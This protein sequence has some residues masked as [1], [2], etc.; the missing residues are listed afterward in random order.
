MAVKFWNV[1]AIVAA[2]LGLAVPEGLDSCAIG[3]P[4][5]V[6]EARQ[7]PADLHRAYVEGKLGVLWPSYE[8]RYLVAAYRILTGGKYTDTEIT[9]MSSGPKPDLMPW[10]D[11]K[12]NWD[13]AMAAFPDR[14]TGY[15][16]Q[17][18][19]LNQ[20]G[21]FLYFL[22]CQNESL[23]TAVETLRERSVRWGAESQNVKDWAQGQSQVFSNCSGKDAV[24]PAALPAGSDKLLAA[25]RQ[26]QIAAAYFYA[27]DLG[28]AREGFDL[29]AKDSASPWSHL[30]PYLAARCYIRQATLGDDTASFLEAQ[31]RLKGILSDSA[32]KDLREA[33]AKLLDYVQVHLDPISKLRELAPEA[34]K[35]DRVSSFL[36][37]YHATRG[38]TKHKGD[39]PKTDDL[40]DWLLSVE[41]GGTS[42]PVERWRE[43]HQPAWLVA[44]LLHG[45]KDDEV[46]QAARAYSSSAAGYESIAY[47]GMRQ[48]KP[49][50]ERAWA[51]ETLKQ[52]ISVSTRNLVR[53]E[54]MRLAE[55]WGDFL[56]FAPRFPEPNFYEFDS[57]EEVPEPKD[58]FPNKALFDTDATGIFNSRLP[59][60]RWADAS[61]DQRIPAD[62][63]IEIAQA[64]WV[65]AVLLGE[66]SMARREMQ[67]LA[68]LTPKR[69]VVIQEYIAALS[70]EDR[71]A[72]AIFFLLRQPD[73]MPSVQP[74][75]RGGRDFSKFSDLGAGRWS[76]KD[77][78]TQT[79]GDFAFLSDQEA[80]EAASQCDKLK[81]DA[82]AGADWLASQT[83]AWAKA[84]PDDP[85]I[86]QALHL[87]V[88]ATRRGFTTQESAAYS[89]QAFDLL[90]AKY[91]KSEWA[92]K[93]KYWFKMA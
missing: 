49:E 18:K 33:V 13:K 19:S 62:L 84:H 53:G 45:A 71:K 77:G 54:R 43:S 61:A 65:R 7:R 17:Y 9:A 36:Y 90:H 22:N 60:A 82:P 72:A 73:V 26:Y 10:S 85:R 4:E 91:P 24:I 25:D 39:L 67:R 81:A 59:L 28:K 89:K 38:D 88:Q 66:D 46:L 56:T 79:K 41:V 31:T 20:N 16:N 63:Q 23:A 6:F 57:R 32:R 83:L 78:C 8:T 29:I 92:L 55:N 50:I 12:M 1:G 75:S 74:A 35:P 47:Y 64:A 5:P 40:V 93:T 42:V 11:A 15:W 14:P 34:W 87:V 30:A 27:V 37:L 68:V 70:A 58:A 52:D 48:A 86:P 51:D 44:A 3:P 80:R 2:V 21:K 69:D 76:F